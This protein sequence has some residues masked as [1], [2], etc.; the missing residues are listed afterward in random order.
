MLS[1][2]C[3]L[4]GCSSNKCTSNEIFL[5]YLQIIVAF[6]VYMFISDTWAWKLFPSAECRVNACLPR[7]IS[8]RTKRLNEGNETSQK[9][10]KLSIC[11]SSLHRTVYQI[12]SSV[13]EI[14]FMRREGITLRFDVRSR[15][16]KCIAVSLWSRNFQVP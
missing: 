15:K 3:T 16:I 7:S 10:K 12:F 9:K 5:Y 1:H 14:W 8:V 13:T 11:V 6:L 4:L 2:L